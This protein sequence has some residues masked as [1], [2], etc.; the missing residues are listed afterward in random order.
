MSIA[1][2]RASIPTEKSGD[3]QND[4]LEDNLHLLLSLSSWLFVSVGFPLFRM[5]SVSNLSFQ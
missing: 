4:A 5:C 1:V 2:N 3:P